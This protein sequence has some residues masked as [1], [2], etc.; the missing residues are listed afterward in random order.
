MRGRPPGKVPTAIIAN[1]RRASWE[2]VDE[3]LEAEPHPSVEADESFKPND[4]YDRIKLP[5]TQI[6]PRLSGVRPILQR[7]GHDDGVVEDIVR[8]L[9]TAR[10][11]NPITMM[12]P[13]TRRYFCA[14]RKDEAGR[15]R[16]RLWSN[17]WC[18]EFERLKRAADRTLLS[19]KGNT[20]SSPRG[21]LTLWHR[22]PRC[23]ERKCSTLRPAPPGGTLSC[24]YCCVYPR[25]WWQRVVDVW[26][27]QS[28]W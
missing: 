8:V 2:G 12:F 25:R 27:R 17:H 10:L 3:P 6:I 5:N 14:G 1:A 21:R 26:R 7:D 16:L 15:L 22:Q 23:C 13:Q 4:I 19:R 24:N 9:R 11:V 20:A 18:D 28:M